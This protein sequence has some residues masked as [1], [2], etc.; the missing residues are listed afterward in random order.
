ML[1]STTSLLPIFTQTL[2][3]YDA[4]TSGMSML[5]RGLGSMISALIVGRLIGKV[6]TKFLL[7]IGFSMLTIST[8]VLSL[9]NIDM[10]KQNI[11]IPLLI[12]GFGMNFVF[13]PLTVISMS[14]L[15]KNEI[16]QG[17]GLYG[18]VRNI[19]GSIGISIVF[20]YQYRLSQVHQTFLSQNINPYNMAYQNF[21]SNVS[22]HAAGIASPKLLGYSLVVKQSALMAYLDAFRLLSLLCFILVIIIF[23]FKNEKKKK[24][25]QA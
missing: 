14:T 8:F 21:A 15:K 24:A 6:N 16:S 4:F 5:P 22:N 12:N 11:I 9:L 25:V 17:T 1:F 20:T 3:G 19:G 13:V 23:M 10:A 2:L 18:L 7:F